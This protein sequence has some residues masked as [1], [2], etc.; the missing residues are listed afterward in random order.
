MTVNVRLYLQAFFVTQLPY[1]SCILTDAPYLSDL[2]GSY[3]FSYVSLEKRP[4]AV[5]G[6]HIA[7]ALSLGL[8]RFS[9][10]LKRH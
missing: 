7:V 8:L 3:D 1:T 2:L 4:N 9:V 10:S 5:T 6:A